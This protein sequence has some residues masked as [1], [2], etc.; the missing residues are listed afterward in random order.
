MESDERAANIRFG[1]LRTLVE[2]EIVRGPVRRKHGHG[3]FGLIAI[4]N[5]LATVAA[6]FRSK[7]QLSSEPDRNSIAA[8]RT[9]HLF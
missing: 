3:R 4:A 7:H 8:S 9:M 6:V 5:L 1:K 2:F